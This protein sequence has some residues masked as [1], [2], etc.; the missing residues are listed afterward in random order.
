MDDETKLRF[1]FLLYEN[2]SKYCLSS[3][4]QADVRRTLNWLKVLC[5]LSFDD[6][7]SDRRK[8]KFNEIFWHRTNEPNG[9]SDKSLKD[10]EVYELVL[11]NVNNRRARL[12]GIPYGNTYYIVWFD[13]NHEVTKARKPRL[14]QG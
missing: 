6:L 11:F 13:Y 2:H 4:S 1:S 10:N 7:K 9:F 8:Y 12:F 5:N 14:I 3:F